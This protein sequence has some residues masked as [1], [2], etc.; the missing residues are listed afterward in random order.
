MSKRKL[1]GGLALGLVLMLVV[2]GCGSK[3]SGDSEKIVVGSMGSD[4]QI[5]SYNFI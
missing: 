3:S 4:A 5:W 1:W 2:A